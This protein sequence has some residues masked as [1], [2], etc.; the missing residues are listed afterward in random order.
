MPRRAL[1]EH[2]PYLLLSLIA[3]I[4]YYFVVDDPIGGLWLMLW[5][6]LAVGFLALYAAHRGLGRDSML[7][8]VVFALAALGD[9]MLDVSLLYA[10]IL[11]T[12]SHSTAII[13]Y[14]RNHREKTTVSQKLVAVAFIF[15]VPA[16]AL[17][18]TLS[19]SN[20]IPATAYAALIGA[21]AAGSWTSRFPRYRGGVGAALFVASHLLII[22]RETNH[23]QADTANLFIWPLY[24]VGQFLIATGVVQTIRKSRNVD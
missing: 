15:L 19:S 4:S 16:I 13:L 10:G 20:A 8:S 1:A 23:V 5:K 6:G 14:I 24:F 3:G 9:V 21:M 12:L 18:L 2:R 17:F 7:L 11:F 22:A